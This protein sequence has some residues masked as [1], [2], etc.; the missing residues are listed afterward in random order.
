[1]ALNTVF[2]FKIVLFLI[3]NISYIRKKDLAMASW[4]TTSNTKAG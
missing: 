1:M 3:L 2:S 4:T